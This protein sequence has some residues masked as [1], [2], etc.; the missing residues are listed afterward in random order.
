MEGPQDTHQE[1]EMSVQ[2]DM[3]VATPDSDSPAPLVVRIHGMDCAEEVSTLRRELALLVGEARLVFDVLGG[4]LTIQR[5]E[6]TLSFQEVADAVARTGMRAERWTAQPL[7]GAS[8]ARREQ[9]AL[10]VASGS[11]AVA[12]FALH[13]W[14][15]RGVLEALGSEGMGLAHSVP[16]SV[17]LL[18]AAG[19]VAG[20]WRIAPKAWI[21]ARHLRPDMNLLMT[22]AVAGA[23]GLGEW[24]EAATV[25]F[26]FSL[27][28]ALESWSVGR[29]R[30]AVAA[31]MDLA[32]P[33]ARMIAADGSEA[34]VSPSEVPVGT[35]FVVRP[36]E[37]VPLDGSVTR[38]SSHVNEAPITGESRP[39]T[40]EPGAQVYAGSINGDGV[41]EVRCTKPAGDT[42]LARIIRMVREAQA[43]RAPS[44]QWVERFAR[45]YTPAVMA[46]AALVLLVPPLFLGAAWADWLYRSLVLLVIGCP[47]ALVI[48]TPV[49]IVASMAAA[50]RQGI[51]VKAGLYVEAPAHLKALC[52]DKT[53]T[54][55]TGR[56]RVTEVV[57]MSGHDDRELLVIAAS[58][59]QRSGHPLARAIVEHA[60]ERGVEMRAAEAVQAL[61]GKG[62]HGRLD[63]LDYWL[64]SH[65]YLEERGQETP[66][67]HERLSALAATGRSVVVVGNETHVCGFIALDDALRPESVDAIASLR[68]LGVEHV[69]MLTGDN[70]GTAERIAHQV[71]VDEVRAE[72]LPGDKLSAVEGLVRRHEHVAMIG[73]GVNDAPAMARATL[74]IAMGAIGSDAAI[75]TADVALMSDDLSK[76]PWLIAHSRR[77][78]RIIRQNITV[79]LAVK[80]TFVA[81]TFLGHASLWGA[82]AADMGA[83]LLVI[84]NGL[85]LLRGSKAL[86]RATA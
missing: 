24:F 72:L 26:L 18:Y 78:L 17:R 35:I 68:R 74:G 53:G 10:T 42:T 44:E 75:E 43:Q 36:G 84:F 32:P 49:S 41:I 7:D 21:S 81:L 57:P 23:V 29:A 71:G 79:S 60:G 67:V 12:G 9:A 3:G 22:V 27:S 11:F 47:C 70:R 30:R 15:A 19:I 38:G 82:I 62:T 65:R 4:T 25:A 28:L 16:L 64:G 51:L 46:I 8:Q 34:T 58:L 1:V 37:R 63:G 2:Q 6:P 52:L 13:A 48:S 14:T 50:A 86:S 31:L 76:V 80:V 40:K 54:L 55:T 5:G 56:P 69:V 20:G 59:E 77:T 61:P 73:D 45:I 85:R 33:T 83:S 39:A 66:A